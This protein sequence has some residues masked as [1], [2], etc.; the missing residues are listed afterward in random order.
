METARSLLDPKNILE[1]NGNRKSLLL[2]IV[3]GQRFNGQAPVLIKLVG[4]LDMDS[5]T[6]TGILDSSFLGKRENEEEEF[7][8]G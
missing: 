1:R 8:T 7:S 2:F 6:T 5:M 4:S 3:S